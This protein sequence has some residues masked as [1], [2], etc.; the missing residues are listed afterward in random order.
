MVKSIH[1]MATKKET[2][3]RLSPLRYCLVWGLLLLALAYGI[4]RYFEYR[5]AELDRRIELLNQ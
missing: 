1:I 5:N 2:P 4:H 3:N